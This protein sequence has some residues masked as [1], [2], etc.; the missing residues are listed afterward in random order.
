MIKLQTSDFSIGDITKN[1]KKGNVGAVVSFV[2]V[3]RGFSDS[4]KVSKL[5]YEYYREAAEKSLREIEKSAKKKFAVQEVIIIHRIGTIKPSQNVIAVAVSAEHR[6]PAFQA[7][8]FIMDEIKKKVPI[9]KKEFIRGK[10][11]WVKGEN[12]KS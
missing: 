5:E 10:G 8:E 4:R 7:C 9:W 2:G 12:A 6:K 1:L 3:V 11:Q